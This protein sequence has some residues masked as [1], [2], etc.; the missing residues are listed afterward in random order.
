MN[1]KPALCLSIC[2]GV[3]QCLMISNTMIQITI[4]MGSGPFIKYIQ[5]Y[6]ENCD[7]NDD[8]QEKKKSMQLYYLKKKSIHY[9]QIIKKRKF[10]EYQKKKNAF[11][12]EMK[13]R[14]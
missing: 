9:F 11:I 6:V 1:R 10:R 2:M 14:K 5:E 3:Y 4:A 7:Y 13:Q 8:F 12:I